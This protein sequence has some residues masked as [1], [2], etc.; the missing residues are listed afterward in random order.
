VP[1]TRSTRRSKCCCS[2]PSCRASSSWRSRWSRKSST[3]RRAG[4][5]Y[6]AVEP[7]NRVVARTLEREWEAWLHELEHV[8][9]QCADARLFEHLLQ[10]LGDRR[11]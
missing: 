2:T 5:R 6:K 10:L 11:G 7:E 4:R 9:R 3:A 8:E 1:G